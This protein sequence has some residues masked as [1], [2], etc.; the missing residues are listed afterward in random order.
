MPTWMRNLTILKAKG[1][2]MTQVGD[3]IRFH[4]YNI[5]FPPG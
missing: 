2:D 3:M 4:I 1:M 5:S